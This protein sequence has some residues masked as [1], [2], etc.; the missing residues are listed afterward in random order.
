MCSFFVVEVLSPDPPTRFNFVRTYHVA[1]F[2]R[3][4]FLIPCWLL[5]ESVFLPVVRLLLSIPRIPCRCCDE[6]ILTRTKSPFTTHK[7]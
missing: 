6:Y 7:V 2:L 1:R 5:S 3:Y 4:D